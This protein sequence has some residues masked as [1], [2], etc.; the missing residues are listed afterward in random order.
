[1][2]RKHPM[3]SRKG[4]LSFAAASL[5]AM[6]AATAQVAGVGATGIDATGQY[7][8]EV[9]AC[10]DGRT[11]QDIDT[12]LRE[13]RNAEAERRKGTLRVQGADH[14]ANAMARCEPFTNEEEKAACKAR[15]LGFGNMTGSVAGGGVL[16]EVE[17]VVAPQGT[18]ELTIQ[19]KTSEPVVLVPV[20]IRPNAPQPQQ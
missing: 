12:C 18:T 13:A 7:Q 19:P 11:Q 15:V 5:L 4:L 16:R 1:M 8:S 20:P 6:T 3:R 14:H 2:K 17:T 10:R 9:Q